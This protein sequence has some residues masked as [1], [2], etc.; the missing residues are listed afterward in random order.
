MD[1]WNGFLSS[2][3]S[4]YYAY[5]VL[6]TWTVVW[7]ASFDQ[8]T[9][10]DFCPC[11]H[12]TC[13]AGL[14]KCWFAGNWR[15]VGE[16]GTCVCVC[17]RVWECVRECVSLCAGSL[18]VSLS[19]LYSCTEGES[20]SSESPSSFLTYTSPSALVPIIEMIVN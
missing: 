14:E 1:F 4:H 12:R 8:T 13:L 16:C 20:A 9:L 2:P 5:G 18:C 6:S 17:A 10:L 19:V 15:S 11:V 3:L 7:I